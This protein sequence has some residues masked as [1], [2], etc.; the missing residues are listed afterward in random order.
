[1]GRWLGLG[2]ASLVSIFAPDC[3]TISGGIMAAGDL[4]LRPASEAFRANAAPHFSDGV[5]L[6]PASLGPKAGLIG[7]ACALLDDVSVKG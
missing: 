7:A 5:K 1:M 2:I 6:V 4:L 3:I